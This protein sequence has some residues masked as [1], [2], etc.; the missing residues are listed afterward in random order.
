VHR[1]IRLWGVKAVWSLGGTVRLADSRA[2]PF[3]QLQPASVSLAVADGMSNAAA[4]STSNRTWSAA[5]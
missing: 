3:G 2:A 5:G 4:A 1:G